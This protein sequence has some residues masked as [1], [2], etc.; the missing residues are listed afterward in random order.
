MSDLRTLTVTVLEAK[1]VIACDKGKSSDPYCKL[2]LVD[3]KSANAI[4]GEGFKTKT[5]K[6]T[7]SPVWNETFEFGKKGANLDS[8]SQPTLV[9]NMFD[10]DTFSSEE[11]GR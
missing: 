7:L 3:A 1:D 9:L 5:K 11:M 6:K 2:D 8:K 4:S 10:S